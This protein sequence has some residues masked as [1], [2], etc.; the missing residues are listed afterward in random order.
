VE[1][2]WVVRGQALVGPARGELAAEQA[3]GEPP[4]V[5]EVPA[6]MNRK[7]SA[8]AVDD[9]DGGDEAE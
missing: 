4:V 5:E 6:G 2:G 7:E 1:P 3:V 9:N 8:E